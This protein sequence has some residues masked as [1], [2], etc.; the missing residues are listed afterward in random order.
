[1]PFV[2]HYI[3]TEKKKFGK[4]MYND[5]YKMVGIMVQFTNKF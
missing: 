5:A 3:A 4:V 1:M 2:E